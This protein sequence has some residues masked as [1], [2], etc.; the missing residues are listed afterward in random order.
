M[1]KT[2]KLKLQEWAASRTRSTT[3]FHIQIQTKDQLAGF[4]VVPNL[5]PGFPCTINRGKTPGGDDYL[6]INLGMAVTMTLVGKIEYSGEWP[7]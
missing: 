6:S 1:K 2:K 4:V 7:P 3:G 5:I